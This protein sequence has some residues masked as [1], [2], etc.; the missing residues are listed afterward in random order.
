M[1]EEKA[2][3]NHLEHVLF[4]LLD[5]QSKQGASHDDTMLM[6]GLLNLLGIVSLM[7]KQMGSA[8]VPQA[9][10]ASP[11]PMLNTLLQMMGGMPGG[12][13]AGLPPGQPPTKE[14]N[15]P[16]L[17]LNPALLMA[18]MNQQPGQ[19]P[20]PALLLTLLSSMM[21][22]QGAPPGRPPA[23]PSSMEAK[24]PLSP[25]VSPPAVSG[26]AKQKVVKWGAQLE[27]EK[28]A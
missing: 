3:G 23:V 14:Q 20:D 11:N 10:P 19:G 4:S 6:L 21:G 12:P 9:L 28:R 15:T 7:N 22:G 24:K 17:P 2:K 1:A 18:L 16:P 5:Y 26:D 25:P 13:P 8:V 27:K